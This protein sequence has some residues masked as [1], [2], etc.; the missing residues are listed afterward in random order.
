M[1]IG[2]G[3]GGGQNHPAS[4]SHSGESDT[5][6]R[7]RILAALMACGGNNT[8]AAKLLGV[9]R[10]TLGKWLEAYD[11]PRPRKKRGKPQEAG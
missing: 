2:P 8:E 5:A 11:I 7:D 1:T 6:K 9:S 4:P 10:R 3:K